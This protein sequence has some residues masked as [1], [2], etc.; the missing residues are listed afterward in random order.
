MNTIVKL[1]IAVIKMPRKIGDIIIRLQE[2]VS[3]LT[4]NTYFPTGWI[5]TTLTQA[6]F[7]LDV[8]A[9]ITQV[10]NVK[11]R[12]AGAVGLR[13][14]AWITLKADFQLILAMVQ[15]KANANESI[16]TAIINS[17]GFFVRTSKARVKQTNDAINTQVLGTVLLTADAPGHHEWQQSKDM[18]TIIPLPGTNTYKTYVHNLNTGD[19]WYFRNHK[20][21]TKKITYNWSPWVK[22]M[23]G[24]GGKTAGGGSLPGHAGSLP[25]A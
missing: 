5:A 24:M 18:V 14:A 10:T 20:V 11:N 25:T 19:V 23:V 16:A 12:V 22:L 7:T 21:N 8:N 3:K 17:V 15:S 1:L 4:N 6:Q 9:Y 2:T 13:N